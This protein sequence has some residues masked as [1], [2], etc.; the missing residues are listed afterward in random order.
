[1]AVARDRWRRP[2]RWQHRSPRVR[3]GLLSA[4]TDGFT[5]TGKHL[6]GSARSRHLFLWDL[7]GLT[8]G[9]VLALTIATGS[10][11]AV[12]AAWWVVALVVAS[13]CLVDVAAELYQHSW[14][15]ASVTDMGRIVFCLGLGTAASLGLVLLAGA[16]TG[17]V[18]PFSFWTT[19]L[20]FAFA[21]VARPR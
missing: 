5:R 14:R 13:R 15:F 8:L 10:V 7:V 12:V 3:D 20:L 17:I 6:A 21:V 4:L 1:M 18:P 19:E 9:G 16:I 2:D 11:G